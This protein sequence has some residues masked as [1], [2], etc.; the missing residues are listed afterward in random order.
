MEWPDYTRVVQ[1]PEFADRVWNQFFAG[2]IQP[3]LERRS[4]HNP[5]DFSDV[6]RLMILF[7][8]EGVP[9]VELNDEVRIVYAVEET[10]GVPRQ[11]GERLTAFETKQIKEI[12]PPTI[13]DRRVAYFYAWRV[14]EQILFTFDFSPNW[15]DFDTATQKL[16]AQLHRHLTFKFLERILEAILHAEE[17]LQ[18]IG[19]SVG[20]TLLPYPINTM[21]RLI[22]A[23]MTSVAMLVLKDHCDPAFITSLVDKWFS[24]GCFLD[25]KP[26]FVET[27]QAFEMGQHHLVINALIGQVEGVITD[28][29]YDVLED[30]EETNFESPKQ[31]FNRF[32]RIMYSIVPFERVE[33]LLVRS[34]C[35][36]LTSPEAILRRF[37]WDDPNLNTRS[38][39]RHAIQHGK[40]VREDYT[41][42]N[43]IK[44]YL[45]LDNIHWCI[46]CYET[47]SSLPSAPSEPDSNTGE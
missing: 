1:D 6:S 24:L 47:Y 40:Y 26:L 21:V 5:V 38:L 22:D 46:E 41:Q 15:P 16:T 3:E 7:P 9:I 33:S 17:N 29:L 23:E 42:E 20:L 27:L 31:K 36:F 4:S 43:S 13:E 28:W 10:E 30:Q 37:R 19:M 45:L 44:L 12:L 14:P 25:R 11:R 39:S 2:I 34:A 8:N 35:D 32:K 18:K